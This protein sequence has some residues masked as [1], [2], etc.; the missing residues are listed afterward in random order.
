MFRE[1][2]FQTCEI[3]GAFDESSLVGII[4]FRKDWIDQLYVAPGVRDLGL[5]GEEADARK[6]TFLRIPAYCW[7]N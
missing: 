3:L 1:I 5:F 4:A 7:S 2:V 6:Q